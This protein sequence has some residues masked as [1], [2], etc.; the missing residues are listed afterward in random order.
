[1]FELSRENVE[2]TRKTPPKK[3]EKTR[4]TFQKSL[5]NRIQRVYTVKA[6]ENA[7][8][9]E[10]TRAIG[11]ISAENCPHR[12][13]AKGFAKLPRVLKN[14]T[15]GAVCRNLGALPKRSKSV[16]NSSLASETDPPYTD[17]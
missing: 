7:K 17:R 10:V 13:G 4:K 9:R 15:P 16:E 3:L 5:A 11:R 1:V 8:K 6:C 12:M 2:I 14:K